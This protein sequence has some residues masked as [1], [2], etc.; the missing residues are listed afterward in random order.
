MTRFVVIMAIFVALHVYYR[1]RDL[2]SRPE[3]RFKLRKYPGRTIYGMSEVC[4]RQCITYWQARQ[5]WHCKSRANK[6]SAKYEVL[7]VDLQTS[8]AV[9]YCPLIPPFPADK[10]DM[11]CLPDYSRVL[12][13]SQQCLVVF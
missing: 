4:Q 3:I 6:L 12:E 10:Q 1:L 13:K 8:S 5:P 11:L 2:I 9:N 7:S